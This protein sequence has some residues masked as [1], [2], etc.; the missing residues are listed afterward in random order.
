[1]TANAVADEL[2]I[3]TIDPLRLRTPEVPVARDPF[4]GRQA[5][6]QIHPLAP[7]ALATL[8]LLLF[9]RLENVHFIHD[10]LTPSR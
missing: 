10:Q 4:S 3:G 6:V 1:V 2:V 5:E 8:S 9:G 7:Q